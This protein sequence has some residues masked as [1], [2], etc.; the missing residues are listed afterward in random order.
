MSLINRSIK[1]E[2]HTTIVLQIII[3]L[4]GAPVLLFIDSPW[5]TPYFS[6]GQ[7]VAN[8]IMI[9]VYSWYLLVARRRLFWLILLM[10]IAG[11][12][13]EVIGSKIL[14]LY[15]Y[16]LQNIPL[17]IPLGHAIIYA[18]SYHLCSQPLIWKNKKIIEPIMCRIAFLIVLLSLFILKDVAGFLLYLLFL[19]ILRTRTKPLFYFGIFAI[20]YYIELFGTVFSTWAWY[21]VIGNH[22][23][24]PPIGFTPSGV[25]GLYVLIDIISN[26]IYFHVKKT[27]KFLKKYLDIL[28]P[29]VFYVNLVNNK[30][31]EKII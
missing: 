5:I 1:L 9:L 2:Y 6:H 18:T 4:L 28:S 14:T 7:D 31:K 13:A 29:D 12:C 8:A 15:Q 17:Y 30:V 23:N 22:P 19:A 16:R 25:A 26:A 11:L 3:V 21:V 24:L 20:V 10:T 27:L